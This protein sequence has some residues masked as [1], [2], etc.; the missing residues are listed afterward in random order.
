MRHITTCG[1]SI[2]TILFH[3]ISYRVFERK[4]VIEYEMWFYFL[5]NVCLKHSS[6]YEELSEI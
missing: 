1:L 2:S 5:Y 4:K 3:I 6:F